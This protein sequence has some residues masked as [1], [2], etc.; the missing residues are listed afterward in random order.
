M[1]DWK[2]LI[3]N[4]EDRISQR[5]EAR[6]V[7]M[8]L[9]DSDRQSCQATTDTDISKKTSKPVEPKVNNS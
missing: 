3:K 9:L 4:L 2:E 6:R 8:G 1:T 5:P 7:N